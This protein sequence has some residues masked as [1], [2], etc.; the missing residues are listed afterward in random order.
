MI[1]ISV[2]SLAGQQMLI[3]PFPPSLAEVA[4]LH[5]LSQAQGR[6]RPIKHT[7]TCMHRTWPDGHA[8]Y[9]SRPNRCGCTRAILSVGYK[10]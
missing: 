3:R 10:F 9:Q 8:A 7:R 5:Q 1:L 4:F 2:P 6:S